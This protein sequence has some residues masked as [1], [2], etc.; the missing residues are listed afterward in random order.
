MDFLHFPLH[1]MR[2]CALRRYQTSPPPAQFLIYFK[3]PGSNLACAPV[4]VLFLLCFLT[5]RMS[6]IIG[7]GRVPRTLTKETT[8]ACR[9]NQTCSI[10]LVRPACCASFPAAPHNVFDYGRERGCTY[11][12]DLRKW[13]SPKK[14]Y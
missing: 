14:A 11:G 12:I 1:H 5:S 6:K 2:Q 9:T 13:A 4:V 7:A 10:L 8:S 3:V